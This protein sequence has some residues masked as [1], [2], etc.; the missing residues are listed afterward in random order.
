MCCP[1]QPGQGSRAGQDQRRQ[2]DL[3]GL[4]RDPEIKSLNHMGGAA[5][6]CEFHSE[7]SPTVGGLERY[8][9]Q[10][11]EDSSFSRSALQKVQTPSSEVR[12]ENDNL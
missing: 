4:H 1:H 3:Q 12:D 2:R 9:L 7:L 5:R 11:L 10:Q 6:G 8:V